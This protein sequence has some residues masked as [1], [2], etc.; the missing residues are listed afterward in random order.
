MCDWCCS[1]ERRRQELADMLAAEVSVVP[2][3]RLLALLQQ[4]RHTRTYGIETTCILDVYRK[5]AGPGS[6]RVEFCPRGIECADLCVVV[7]RC[8]FDWVGIWVQRSSSSSCRA[9]CPRSG[10][11]TSSGAAHAHAPRTSRRRVRRLL[12]ISP[13][14]WLGLG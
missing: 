14:H 8:G 3:S 6:E 4:G 11:T 2:P 9:S 12:H 7:C 10:G 5:P 1:K 13:L